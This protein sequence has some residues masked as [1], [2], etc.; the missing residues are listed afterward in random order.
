MK[1]ITRYWV[2]SIGT[3]KKTDT[4]EDDCME[5]VV[6]SD[7][8]AHEQAWQAQVDELKAEV[9]EWLC[10]QCKIVYPGPPVEG[11]GCVRC[12][13]CGGCCGPRLSIENRALQAQV[14][15]L[16]EELTAYRTGGVTEE[17]LRRNDGAIKVGRGCV[18]VREDDH[19]ALKQENE[20]LKAEL[21][22]DRDQ[23]A[24]TAK[25]A[26][27]ICKEVGILTLDEVP[28]LVRGL[29]ARADRAES[30]LAAMRDK[31]KQL[32]YEISVQGDVS[33]A[34]EDV[35][36]E[37]ESPGHGQRYREAM[38]L[39]Q[40]EVEYESKRP[41]TIPFHVPIGWI[42]RARRVAAL[43]AVEGQ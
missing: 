8:D 3:H 2:H 1:P 13:K 35:V 17:I 42:E 25:E 41:I 11:F 4:C 14:D 26:T 43:R 22:H 6:A 29:K 18:I 24:R 23:G 12:P 10:D 5:V 37:L 19:D 30:A 16:T 32:V 33:H 21:N 20:R 28:E 31:A 36:N 40:E 38:A 15:K 7:H 39:L 9:R 27:A 34:C